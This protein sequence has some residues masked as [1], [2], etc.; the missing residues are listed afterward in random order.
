MPEAK[1]IIPVAIILILFISL[2]RILFKGFTDLIGGFILRDFFNRY[3][4]ILPLKP[5]YLHILEKKSNFYQKLNQKNKKLFEKRVNKFIA[6]K[7]F[8]PRGGLNKVTSEMKT[9]IAATAIQITFGYPAIY[10]E[11]FWRI[12]IYP[13]TYYSTITKKHHYGEINLHGLIIFSWKKFVEGY[14]NYADG[15]NLALHE[16]AHALVVENRIRNSENNFLDNDLLKL[17]DNYYLREKEIIKADDNSFFRNYST[18]NEHE[19][20]SVAVEN[21]FERPAEFYQYNPGLYAVTSRILK[22]DLLKNENNNGI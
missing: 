10:F 21:F 22:Q 6:M 17:F 8:I 14:Q 7:K 15:K 12:L 1:D 18:T 4:L 9:L 16:M 13:D 11:H 19:F 20:F 3:F 5:E 2:T